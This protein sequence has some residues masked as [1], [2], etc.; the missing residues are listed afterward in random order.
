MEDGLWAGFIQ[1]LENGNTI[2]GAVS[3]VFFFFLCRLLLI[4]T[5]DHWPREREPAPSY[6]DSRAIEAMRSDYKQFKQEMLDRMVRSETTLSIRMG[7]MEAALQRR[8]GANDTE[9]NQG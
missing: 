1:S 7:N 6:E 5:R 3:A 8:P 4:K 9:G 2:W